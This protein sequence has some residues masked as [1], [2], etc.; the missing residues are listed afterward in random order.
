M[1][2]TKNYKKLQR[3][4]KANVD[5]NNLQFFFQ[6]MKTGYQFYQCI[7]CQS[8]LN[9][10]LGI[11]SHLNGQ[12]HKKNVK[13][14]FQAYHWCL[15]DRLIQ[16]L[17]PKLIEVCEID[18][19]LVWNGMLKSKLYDKFYCQLCRKEMSSVQGAVSHVDG[20]D[21]LKRCRLPDQTRIIPSCIMQKI[22]GLEEFSQYRDPKIPPPPEVLFSKF[23]KYCGVFQEDDDQNDTNCCEQH[24]QE[25]ERLARIIVRN[26]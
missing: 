12:T 20:K 25:M 21:H 8:E 7:I 9:G 10:Q 13:N 24:F 19:F 5:L 14:Y 4:N 1:G 23:C 22:Q 2:Q 6:E 18:P 11:R 15:D 17:D 26:K 3:Q 16:D